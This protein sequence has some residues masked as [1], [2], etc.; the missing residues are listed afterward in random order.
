ME[1]LDKMGINIFKC[2]L[3]YLQNYS[4]WFKEIL[5]DLK[6]IISTTIGSY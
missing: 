2:L 1:L 3:S 4:L 5:R 6:N